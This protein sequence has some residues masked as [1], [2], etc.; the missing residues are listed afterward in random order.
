MTDALRR[1]VDE[2]VVASGLLLLIANEGPNANSVARSCAEHPRSRK[3]MKTGK[4]LED[5]Q[6]AEEEEASTLYPNM[7]SKYHF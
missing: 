7:E 4:R 6:C 5:G 1:W 2:T 3:P